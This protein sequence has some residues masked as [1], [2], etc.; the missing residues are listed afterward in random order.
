MSK[1]ILKKQQGRGTWISDI[2]T[3]RMWQ[4]E[5]VIDV[6]IKTNQSLDQKRDS[7]TELYLHRNEHQKAGLVHYPWVGHPA[8]W[9][10]WTIW[11]VKLPISTIHAPKMTIETS[12]SLSS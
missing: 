1:A 3:Y 6:E 7:E 2:K 8:L 12:L 4:N 10:H 9:I 11:N 5:F